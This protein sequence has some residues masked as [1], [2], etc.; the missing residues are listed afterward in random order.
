MPQTAP[1][2][3]AQDLSA[4]GS[5]SLQVALPILAAFNLPQAVLPTKLLSTQTEGFATPVQVDLNHWLPQVFTHWQQQQLTFSGLLIGYLGRTDLMTTMQQ[6]IRQQVL[7]LIVVDPVMADQNALYPGLPKDYPQALT[8][9]LTY[10]TVVTPNLTEAQLLTGISVSAQPTLA[11]QYHLLK[12]LEHKLPKNGHAVIT[13]VTRRQQVGCI[14]L[15]N[16]QVNYFGQAQLTGH[17]FG[18][19]DVFTAL[20][21]GFLHYEKTFSQAVKNAISCTFLA[22]QQTANSQ[23]ERRYG[24]C[25]GDVL[26]ALGQYQKSGKLLTK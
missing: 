5:L 17:F 25:L 2:I 11:E 20:L 16:D 13:S 10:A 26:V 9:L 15:V 4:I 19:G 23:Q 14:W 22:L 3:V 21:T 8:Q 12:A 18:S 24:I 1:L 7:P 6:L